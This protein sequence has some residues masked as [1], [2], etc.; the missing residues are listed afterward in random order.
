MVPGALDQR[1]G[2]YVY[3][4]RMVEGLRAAGREVVV[5]ELAGNFP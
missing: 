3:D 1:T 4:R 5:H 2:G